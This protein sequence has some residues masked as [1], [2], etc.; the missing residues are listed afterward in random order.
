M[1]DDLPIP[2]ELEA[3]LEKR[4]DR[5]RRKRPRRHEDALPPDERSG[6]ATYPERRTR[7]DRRKHKRRRES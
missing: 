2:P 7:R 1:S 4:S 5:D 3:L 6:G